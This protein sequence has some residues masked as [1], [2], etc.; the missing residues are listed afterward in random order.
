[1]GISVYLKQLLGGTTQVLAMT[2]EGF[3]WSKP[4]SRQAH[5]EVGE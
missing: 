1:M 5:D 4:G 3:T 2:P